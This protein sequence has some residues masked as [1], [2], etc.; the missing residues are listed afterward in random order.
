[1]RKTT[2]VERGEREVKS[3]RERTAARR[4]YMLMLNEFGHSATQ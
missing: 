2:V 1:M 3:E 4:E